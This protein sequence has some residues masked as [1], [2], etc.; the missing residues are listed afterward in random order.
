VRL[1]DW[2]TTRLEGRYELQPALRAI[3]GG[4]RLGGLNWWAIERPRW[5]LGTGWSLTPEIAGMTSKDGAGPHKRPADAFL[6]RDPTPLR[7]M[8]GARYLEPGGPPAVVTAALD[9]K[10]LAEWP[11]S[12]GAPW[13]VQWIDLPGGVPDGAGPYGWLTVSVRS[14][15]PSRP[16]PMVGL[17]QF[18]AAPAPDFIFAFLEDWNELEGN[19]STGQLWR[20]TT[21]RS[22]MLIRRGDRGDLR[23]FIEGD[24]P[25]RDFDRAPNVVVKA[26]DHEL[27]RFSPADAFTREIALPAA[28]LDASDGRVTIE[29]DLTFVPGER[30]ASADRRKLG[31]RLFKVEVR[32]R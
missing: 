28:A 9:G 27:A 15:D 7:L 21:A 2:R 16:P 17:E 24:S 29:T 5:M 12:P 31:L 23:L 4:V 13:F 11:L 6:R 1:F 3:M 10:P 8:L 18:D 20:W 32:G 22:T 25:L 26:G 19:S 14:T 30:R